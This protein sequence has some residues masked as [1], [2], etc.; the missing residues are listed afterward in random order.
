MATRTAMDDLTADAI[1]RALAAAA[2]GRMS[3]ARTLGEKALASGGDAATLNAM[4]GM[5]HSKTGDLDRAV[6]HLRVALGARP[7]DPVIANNLASALLQLD[8]KTEAL[9][10]LD[11]EVVEADKTGQLLKLRAFLAQMTD[12]FDLAVCC[13]EQ[14]VAREPADLESWNNLGNAYRSADNI[15]KAIEALRL[16][17]ALDSRTAPIR[18]NLATA[19]VVAGDW[20]G[21]EAELRAMTADFPDDPNPWRELHAMLRQSGR[22]DEA[23]D[24]IEAALKRAPDDKELLLGLG[25]H[26]SYIQRAVEAETAYRRVLDLEAG[27]SL[28]HLGLA[29]IFDANNRTDELTAIV[30]Q[31]EDRGIGS[32]SL[33]FMRALDHRRAR[34][35]AEGLA[36]MEQVPE[37]LESARRAH[38]MGQLLEGV[39]RY[40]E[41]MESYARMNAFLVEEIPQGEARGA[42]YRE[43]IRARRDSL[44]K[45]WVDGW[46][47]ELERESRPSPVFLVGFP[48]SGTTLLDTMLMGHPSI[49]VLEEEPTLHE[50]FRT[51]NHND[52]PNATDEQIRTARDGYFA[53]AASLTP[54]KPGNLL[55]DKNPLAMNALPYIRRLFPNARIILALRHPCDCVLSCY[56]TNF[57]LNDGMASFTQL[58][59]AADLYDLSFSY[60]ERVQELMPIPTHRVVYENVVADRARELRALFEFLQLDWHD[61]VLDHQLTAMNRGRIKTASYAQVVEPIYKRSAGRWQNFRKHLDPVMPVLGPWAEKFGYEI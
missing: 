43:A 25:G 20:D 28:A 57:N 9:D 56:V 37:D 1:R 54:L 47:Q 30:R 24:A 51:I 41:A 14:V 46:R 15:E 13:Y 10:V 36:A 18:L 39:G 29:L 48:R 19:L 35:F 5:L 50:A 7:R 11:D 22:D 55:I 3:E 23:T 44:S 4:L 17:V 52:L 27:N 38:L 32:Q 59:T 45:A 42:E 2:S 61:A 53:T 34:R 16:A 58:D 26:L 40:D 12:Q 8:R 49:E 31:A 6:Q 60:F 33:N 21:A